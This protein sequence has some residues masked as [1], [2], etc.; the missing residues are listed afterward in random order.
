MPNNAMLNK[1]ILNEV[2]L[3]LFQHPPSTNL[4]KQHLSLADPETSSG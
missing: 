2:M 1:S 3:N 4:P